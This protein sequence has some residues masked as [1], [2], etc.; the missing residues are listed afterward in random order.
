[1]IY[2]RTGFTLAADPVLGE[3]YM[4]TELWNKCVEYHGHVCGGITIGYMAAL[5]AGELL[6]IKA[7]DDVHILA[8]TA[9]CPVDAFPV[10]LNCSRENSRL[11][12]E[13][14]DEMEFEVEN[15]SSG[16]S[17]VLLAKP[18]PEGSEKGKNSLKPQGFGEA[19]VVLKS[20]NNLEY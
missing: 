2:L 10:I 3:M 7:G 15:R 19:F 5:Y 14:R 16:K 1:M 11:E 6:D 9:G 13:D 12:I 20:I 18:K 17:V 4:N 8:A